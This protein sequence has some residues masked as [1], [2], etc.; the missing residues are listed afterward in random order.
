[1]EKQDCTGVDPV[2]PVPPPRPTLAHVASQTDLADEADAAPAATSDQADA[3]KIV[4]MI[5]H[6]ASLE[7]G[8][9][10]KER[11]REEKRLDERLQKGKS[12]ALGGGEPLVHLA[13]PQRTVRVLKP[14]IE[15]ECYA[16]DYPKRGDTYLR[17]DCQL[18][19]L[20]L[21]DA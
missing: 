5:S 4:P 12:D 20:L 10:K 11:E 1:M 21:L 13:S 9:R 2:P 7:Q 19:F 8:K 16:M 6:L 15:E 3:L 18:V 17:Q 14:A